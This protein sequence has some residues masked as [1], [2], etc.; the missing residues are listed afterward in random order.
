MHEVLRSE[1]EPRRPKGGADAEG[2][3]PG[4]A[5]TNGRPQADL[6]AQRRVPERFSARGVLDTC[7]ND[8]Y[9][10]F[11]SM[12]SMFNRFNVEVVVAFNN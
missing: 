3:T 12:R 10:E 5:L 9:V 2:V 6:G 4:G 8:T 1:A 11:Y 7:R